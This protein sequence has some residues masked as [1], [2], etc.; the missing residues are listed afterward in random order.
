MI[1]SVLSNSHYPLQLIISRTNTFIVP[2]P[3]SAPL[4]LTRNYVHLC[5]IPTPHQAQPV[6]SSFSMA[7]LVCWGTS[8]LSTLTHH[9][10]IPSQHT[11]MKV[12]CR[13]SVRYRELLAYPRISRALGQLHNCWH[14]LHQNSEWSKWLAGQ[15]LSSSCNIISW[16]MCHHMPH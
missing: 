7:A 9:P 5:A 14:E 1:I 11:L 12:S 2:S 16:A 13:M 4:H 8:N 15:D 3:A 10:K 6:T